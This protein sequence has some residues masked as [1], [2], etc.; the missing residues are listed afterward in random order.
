MLKL[1][2]G[3]KVELGKWHYFSMY[4][5]NYTSQNLF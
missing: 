3:V 4:Y 1:E 2:L 5:V